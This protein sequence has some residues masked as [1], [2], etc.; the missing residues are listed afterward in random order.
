ME[1]WKP[2]IGFEFFYSVSISGQVRSL[3]QSKIM[4]PSTSNTG[5]YPMYVFTVQGKRT[6]KY[7]HQM[8][9]EAF[10]GPCPEGMEVR[11]L[12][13]DASN[14]ALFSPSGER[15]LAWGTKS[16][17]NFD[18]VRHGT[19]YEASRTHCENGHEWTKENTRIERYPDGTFK[20]RRCRECKRLDAARLRS[21]RKTDIRR[22][23]EP[24]CGKP[25][26]GRNWCSMHYARWYTKQKKLTA[27]EA[28]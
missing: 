4:R 12:D 26:F 18:E 17:N 9:M 10:V 15:R 19:H 23:K 21:Q 16:E 2:V 13:G 8:V 11:H 27:S 14:P 7:A 5:G 24:D 6:G 22:C 1:N 25:Y 20:A 28:A 3:R